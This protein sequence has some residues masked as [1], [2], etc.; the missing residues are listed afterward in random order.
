MNRIRRSIPNCIT[1]LRIVGTVALLFV[2]PFTLPFYILYTLTGL[3]DALDGAVARAT[4]TA[5]KWGARL[6]SVADLL[7]YTVMLVRILPT[8]LKLLP[9]SV[10]WIVGAALLIR[11]TSYTVAAV[12]YR[13]FASLH[14]YLNKA[15]G[16]TVFLIPYVI[17]LPI[18]IPICYGTAAMALLSSL[19]ELVIHL[20][21]REYDPNCRTLLQYTETEKG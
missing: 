10:W 11:L 14:T 5:S 18:A 21:R 1:A 9:M 6:D 4:H 13:Q 12:R 2:V 20:C 3:T 8:L 15:T 16:L 17:R 19:E 7:F